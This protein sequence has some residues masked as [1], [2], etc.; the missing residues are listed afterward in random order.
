MPHGVKTFFFKV[1][2]AAF[3]FSTMILAFRKFTEN[4]A[5]CFP[6]CVYQWEIRPLFT[7]GFQLK[8]LCMC[9][10]CRAR[11]GAG[12]GVQGSWDARVEMSTGWGGGSGCSG[13]E[14][15]PGTSTHP[16]G[17]GAEGAPR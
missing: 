4:S 12:P 17:G 8:A 13:E 9:P 10:V 7:S 3:G 1:L 16:L 5:K 11:A 14:L 2:R 15:W 6:V